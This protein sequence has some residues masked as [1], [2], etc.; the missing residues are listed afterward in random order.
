MVDHLER[1]DAL[2]RRVQFRSTAEA[3]KSAKFGQCYGQLADSYQALAGLEEG[4]AKRRL[5]TRRTASEDF[6][7]S[8][9]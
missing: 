2:R 9:V 1:A 8:Q 6:L 7:L 5:I 4:F 3:T